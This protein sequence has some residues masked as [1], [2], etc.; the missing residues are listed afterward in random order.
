MSDLSFPATLVELPEPDLPNEAWARITVATGGICGSDLHLFS[1]NTG[2]SPTLYSLGG[3]AFV[4][5]HEI[6]GRIV[7]AGSECP[8]PI[9]TRVAVDPCIP[10]RGTGNRSALRHLRPGLDILV[11]QP[12]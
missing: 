6:A 11:S 1:H 5:G 3:Q 4:F 12:R 9:G 7:E 10:C 8:Y 2:P